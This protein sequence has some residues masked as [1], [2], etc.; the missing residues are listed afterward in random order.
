MKEHNRAISRERRHRIYLWAA[1]SS[2]GLHCHTG[3]LSYGTEVTVG[4]WN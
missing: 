4:V 1:M 2:L 3:I